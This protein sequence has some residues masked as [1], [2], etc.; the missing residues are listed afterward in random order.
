MKRRRSSVKEAQDEEAAAVSAAKQGEFSSPTLR[1]RTTA[2][3]TITDLTSKSFNSAVHA[4]DRP[5]GAARPIDLFGILVETIED[6]VDENEVLR[7][8]LHKEYLQRRGS[9]VARKLAVLTSDVSTRQVLGGP[10]QV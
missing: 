2:A 4:A 5:T 6:M 7:K 1:P 8:H 9:A 10:L 3:A